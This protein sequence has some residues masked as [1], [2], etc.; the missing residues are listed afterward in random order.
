MGVSWSALVWCLKSYSKKRNA[1][2][3]NA[4]AMA[5]DAKASSPVL[6]ESENALRS[7]LYADKEVLLRSEVGRCV[8]VVFARRRVSPP[9]WRQ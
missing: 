3:I 7:G 5:I 4:M 8:N 2:S 9:N 1:V 6:T